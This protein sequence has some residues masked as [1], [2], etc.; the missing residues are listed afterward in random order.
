MMSINPD[1]KYTR[2]R[3]YHRRAKSSTN[4]SK[5]NDNPTR[6]VSVSRKRRTEHKRRASQSTRD[7]IGAATVDAEGTSGRRRH[8]FDTTE[9]Y[10]RN[11]T[12]I[13]VERM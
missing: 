10:N 5:Q 7:S 6:T 13:A 9:H 11:V 1:I 12:E 8:G 4:G 2:V 3:N